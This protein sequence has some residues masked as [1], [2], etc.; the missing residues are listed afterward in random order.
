MEATR[1]GRLTVVRMTEKVYGGKRYK[2]AECRCDCGK[3][4]VYA[5][6]NLTSGATQSCGCYRNQRIRETVVTHG[7]ANTPIYTC[8]I[9]MIQR[10]TSPRHKHYSYYGGRGITVCARW[11]DIA[12]FAADMGEPP[13]K[14][15]LDRIDPNGNY[16]PTNCRWATR[17]QQARNTRVRRNSKSGFKGVHWVPRCNLWYSQLT[18]GDKSFGGYS[19]T[20]LDA[21]AL[22]LRLEREH[23][24]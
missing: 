13:P 11:L 9:G 1:F 2:A 23:W 14:A 10:C 15:T 5:L 19:K 21:V 6:S 12:N 7:L 18:I 3:V 8:W 4:K 20:L 24:T 22:R 17:Q 16:E